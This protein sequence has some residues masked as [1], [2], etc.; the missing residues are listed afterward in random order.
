MNHCEAAPKIAVSASMIGVRNVFVIRAEEER[1]WLAVHALNASAFGRA[2]EA[3]LVE[4]LRQQAHPYISLVAEQDGSVVGH[5][6]F[7]SVALSGHP[8]LKIMGLAPMAVSPQRQRQ[9]VGT[10]LVRAGLEQ[11]KRL[12]FGAVVVLGH[13]QYYPRFGFSPSSQFGIR[14]EYEVPDE[15]FMIVELQPGYLRGASGTVSYLPAFTRC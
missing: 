13:P 6:V 11:C 1:D 14:C 4:S 8:E 5:I 15:A 12:G 9:G 2:D 3:D 10:M 7:T